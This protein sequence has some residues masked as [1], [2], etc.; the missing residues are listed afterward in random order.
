MKSLK[1]EKGSLNFF[2]PFIFVICFIYFK[3]HPNKISYIKLCVLMKY[4]IVRL[5]SMQ[6]PNKLGYFIFTNVESYV[7]TKFYVMWMQTV[8]L[9]A[10]EFRF[11]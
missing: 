8:I 5:I 3:S 10:E 4:F 7:I 9:L 11:N 1:L 6:R 2:L